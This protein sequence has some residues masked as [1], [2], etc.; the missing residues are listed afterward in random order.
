MSPIGHCLSS[1]RVFFDLDEIPDAPTE[2]ERKAGGDLDDGEPDEWAGTEMP[3]EQPSPRA[4]SAA[5]GGFSAAAATSAWGGDDL[6]IEL[7]SDAADSFVSAETGG[8]DSFVM[9]LSGK[10]ASAKWANNSAL[11]ADLCAAGVFDQAMHVLHR[12]I[13]AVNFEPLQANMLAIY[14]AAQCFVPLLTPGH[15]LH[16]PLQRSVERSG[17]GVDLPSQ[18][19][20]KLSHCV[21]TL[22]RAYKFVTEG[23]FP[24]ALTTFTEILHTLPLVVLDRR[25]QIAEVDELIKICR[26]YVTAMRIEAARKDADPQRQFALSA[27]FCSL[28]LQPVHQILGLRVA[29]K[30]GYTLKNFATTSLFCR[31]ALEA[32]VTLNDPA[33]S[34]LVNIKQVKGVL[35]VCE[36]DLKDYV[37][38]DFDESKVFVLCSRTLSPIYRGQPSVSC[39]FCGAAYKTAFDGEL[40][41]SC[42]ISKIGAEAAGLRS[43]VE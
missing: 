24:V 29:M 17:D 10:L 13:G 12:Q 38:V 32:C 40:C 31:R 15:A 27:Y 1:A 30:A 11:A 33:I 19:M 22:K 25:S 5:S 18:N 36:K 8:S 9:P 34:N 37:P 16:I 42:H 20:F 7:P 4:A 14:S 41:N 6:D 21:E 35:A 3:K 39:G 26:E 23:Q 2:E 28:K 43:I